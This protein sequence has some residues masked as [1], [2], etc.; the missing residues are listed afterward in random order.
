MLLIEE[1]RQSE[2]GQVVSRLGKVTRGGEIIVDFAWYKFAGTRAQHYYHKGKPVVGEV[3]DGER[4]GELLI[5]LDREQM[6]IAVFER[7]KEGIAL[8]VSEER[9]GEIRKHTKVVRELFGPVAEGA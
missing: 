4:A 3:K 8:P 6:P 1:I 2:R 5:L 7:G 9:L